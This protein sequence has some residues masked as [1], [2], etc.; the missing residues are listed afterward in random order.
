MEI[1]VNINEAKILEL[2][3]TSSMDH[4]PMAIVN[5]VRREAMEKAANEIKGKLVEKSYY[6]DKETLYGEVTKLVYAQIQDSIKKLVESKFTE[7]NIEISVKHYFEKTFNEWIE[8]KIYERL[9]E[10]KKDI[11]IGSYGELKEERRQDEMAHQDE[12]EAASEQH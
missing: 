3:K 2:A 10:A 1:K 4:L 11:F 5:E 6:G 9:E 7:K 12:L 8:K